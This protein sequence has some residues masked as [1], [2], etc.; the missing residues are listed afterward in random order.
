M[1]FFLVREYLSLEWSPVKVVWC[2]PVRN[3][4][5]QYFIQSRVKPRIEILYVQITTHRNLTSPRIQSGVS[6]SS[7]LNTSVRKQAT[8]LWLLQG[9]TDR[10]SGC[11]LMWE[12]TSLSSHFLH[13]RQSR[14][15][16]SHPNFHKCIVVSTNKQKSFLIAVGR[17]VT[18]N[19]QLLGAECLF[20]EPSLPS[21]KTGKHVIMDNLDY[22][23]QWLAHFLCDTCSLSHP[24]S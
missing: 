10:I 8:I 24:C 7:H 11:R 6:Y 13:M 2:L 16:P 5:N 18:N 21:C 4:D 15:V 12:V 19:T 1:S 20:S 3:D 14:H 22:D 23:I 9:I 17:L